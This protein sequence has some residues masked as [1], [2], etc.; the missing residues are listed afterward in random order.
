MTG[1]KEVWERRGQKI[2]QFKRMK[3]RLE[4]LIKLSEWIF[5]LKRDLR[6]RTSR[7]EGMRGNRK[8]RQGCRSD[9]GTTITQ[10]SDIK[11][12]IG[13]KVKVWKV[14]GN[15]LYVCKYMTIISTW[16]E[17]RVWSTWWTEQ[18][19]KIVPVKS[20]NREMSIK[21]EEGKKKEKVSPRFRIFKGYM[22]QEIKVGRQD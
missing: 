15:P 2:L 5:I 9:K 7:R 17:D 22:L 10:G 6:T 4:W 12:S 20:L 18:T 13:L 16:M 19:E 21:I 11:S 3:M 1:R 14:T 8:Y